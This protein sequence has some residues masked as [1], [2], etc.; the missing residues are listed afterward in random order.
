[1][2]SFDVGP[3]A[4]GDYAR[5]GFVVLSKAFAADLL[6]EVRAEMERVV[7]AAATGDCSNMYF[8]SNQAAFRQESAGV[9]CVFRVE[10]RSAML[11]E[12]LYSKLLLDMVEPLIGDTPVADGVQYI[13]KPP[14][15]S[16]EF[17]YHQDNAYQFYAPALSLTATVALDEQT[18]ESGGI[19]LLVGSHVLPI[20]PHQPS[21]VLGASRGMVDAPDTDRFPIAM[22]TLKAGDLLVHHANVIHRTRKNRTGSHRRNLGFTY[23]GRAATQDAVAAAAFTQ[24]LAHHEAQAGYPTTG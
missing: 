2:S 7:A 14:Y 16:C 15:N 4:R 23:H 13:D 22:P 11:R 12:L 1:M 6:V 3:E 21:G 10:A 8:D 17:P 5:D 20:L 9:R 19:E 24:Q 18:T